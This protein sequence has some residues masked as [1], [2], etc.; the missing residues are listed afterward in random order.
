MRFVRYR[1]PSGGAQ[2]G[3]VN[4]DKIE[5]ITGDLFG[6]WQRQG[7]PV[8]LAGAK[9]LSPVMP[10]NVLCIGRNYAEHAKEGNAEVPTSPLLFIKS[11]TTLNDPEAVVRLPKTAPERVDFEAELVVVIGRAAKNVPEDHALDFVFG[12]TCGNDVSARDVQKNEGQ[13][14]RGKSF[15]GFAPLGP[16]I[17]TELDPADLRVQGRLNGQTM[18]DARTTEMVFGVKQ[19]VSNLSHSMTLL[20]GTAIM[21]GTPSGVGFART[22][23]VFLKPGDVYE[24]EIE[25]IGVLKNSFAAE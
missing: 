12:Y 25:G 4:G 15:D 5:P 20:P 11:T 9:L 16:W 24:V 18:Q 22:P 3:V 14:A 1:L 7:A 10:P 8:P 13:W 17:E 6:T 19:L 21:T 23:P 2:H